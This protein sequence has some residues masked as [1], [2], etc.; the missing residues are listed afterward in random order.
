MARVS[1]NS[2]QSVHVT[3]FGVESMLAAM[4]MLGTSTRHEHENVYYEGDTYYWLCQICRTLADCQVKS[5]GGRMHLFV[6][7][8]QALLTCLFTPHPHS[9]PP[10]SLTPPTWVNPEEAWDEMAQGY[11][12]VLETWTNPTIFSSPAPMHHGRPLVDE[13]RRAREHVAEFVPHLLA[14]Y[15]SLSLA[16]TL[17]W[18]A[19]ED[20]MD[21]LFT[22]IDIV[23]RERLRAMNAG[24]GRDER[25][26]W[27][28]LW[29]DWRR[30]RGPD[31]QDA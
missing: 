8:L 21:G 1:T 7:V 23:P 31:E 26:V 30:D 28:S 3:Q 20:L 29:A 4:A 9:K 17:G 5:L 6:P 2:R 12:R 25:A 10:R 14:H 13:S 15:C 19:R 22:C 27:R 11:K 18:G 24:M 16:G